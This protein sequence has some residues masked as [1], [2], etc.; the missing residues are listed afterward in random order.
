MAI[1]A[2]AASWRQRAIHTTSD[3]IQVFSTA[4]GGIVGAAV[5]VGVSGSG[6]WCRGGG[7]ACERD[8]VPDM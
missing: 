1:S 8:V 7:S 6:E 2:R 5:G 4:T 3:S